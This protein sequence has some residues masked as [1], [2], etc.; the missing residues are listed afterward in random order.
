MKVDNQK[1]NSTKKEKLDSL[2]S[3]KSSNLASSVEKT[4]EKKISE[5][6]IEKENDLEEAINE[7][8]QWAYEQKRLMKEELT[9]PN[10]V[11]HDTHNH[12]KYFLEKI[13]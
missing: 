12:N 4:A 5:I 2:H 9:K 8:I 3:Q 1:E 11:T 10:G 13:H 7:E 6:R